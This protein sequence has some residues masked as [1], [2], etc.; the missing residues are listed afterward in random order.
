MNL[1]V[2]NASLRTIRLCAVKAPGISDRRRATLN[3]LALSVGS[4]VVDP[5]TGDKPADLALSELG[6]VERCESNARQTVF[7][8]GRTDAQAMEAHLGHLRRRAL[9]SG[10]QP[11]R[12]G[13]QERVAMLTSA[14]ALI[15]IGAATELEYQEKID[16]TDDALRTSRAALRE[17]VVPGGGV[18]YLGARRAVAEAA[19]SDPDVAAGVT[20]LITALQAPFPQILTNAGIEAL[21][22][23]AGVKRQAAWEGFNV[24]TGTYGNLQAMGVVD[25]AAIVRSALRHASLAAGMLPTTE[26]VVTRA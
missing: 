26:C 24:A 11:D 1:L 6:S 12:E 18:A 20:T 16:R 15:R 10:E 2:V 9:Q 14:V 13:L 25:A 22:V 19:V 5:M 8:G 7:V 21:P 4:R 23:L 3:D 17:G